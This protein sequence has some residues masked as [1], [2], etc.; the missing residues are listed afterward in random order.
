VLGKMVGVVASTLLGFG[1]VKS[2]NFMGWQSL[3]TAI[4]DLSRSGLYRVV[5]LECES[6]SA[7]QRGDLQWGTLPIGYDLVRNDI[8]I[9]LWY[10]NQADERIILIKKGHA[11]RWLPY[12]HNHHSWELIAEIIPWIWS[13]G[14]PE[15][16]A[17]RLE[18][19]DGWIQQIDH[20]YRSFFDRKIK[21]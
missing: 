6:R 12:H 14:H 21:T 5:L 3:Q 18:P 8:A 11:Q 20:N 15:S 2:H 1:K 4:Y 13:G 17:D 16:I 19:S 7:Y 10:C 9:S